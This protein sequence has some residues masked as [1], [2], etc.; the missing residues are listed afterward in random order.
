[1]YQGFETTVRMTDIEAS[2]TYPNNYI[3][4]RMDDYVS[5]MGTVIGI[6]DTEEETYEALRNLENPAFCGVMEGVRLQCTLGGV[7]VVSG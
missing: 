1:M 4:M 3:I 7:V 5:D 2:E 6:G